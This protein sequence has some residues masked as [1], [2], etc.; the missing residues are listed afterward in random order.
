[1]NPFDKYMNDNFSTAAETYQTVFSTYDKNSDGFLD[2]TEFTELVKNLFNAKGDDTRI[3]SQLDTLFSIIDLNQDGLVNLEEFRYAWFYWIRQILRPVRALIVVDVQ[4]DF[5]S[6]SLSLSKC[7]A[8][9]DGSAVVPVVNSLLNQDLFDIV[10]YSSDWHPEDHISF[11]E[12]VKMRTMHPTSKTDAES[13]KVLDTVVFEFKGVP[14]VQTLWPKHCT[15]G[16]WGAQLHPDLKVAEK[17]FY[18]NKG[19]NPDVDSYSSFWDNDKLSKTEL[20][21]ILSENR[22]T[23]VYVSGLAYDVCVGFTAHHAVEHGFRTIFIEDAARGVSLDG[24]AKMREDLL[25]RGVYMT[26][27]SEVPALTKSEVRPLCL[28]I[29]AALNYQVAWKI[30]KQKTQSS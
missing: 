29:Q 10:V 15:Q 11:V 19:M 24:I 17:A 21:T 2:E 6:G 20:S 5:I 9:Q 27:S 13:A 14:R 26:D 12:N 16:S 30:V 8:G 22:V 25:A 18:I 28:G 7:A 1:M 4:N 23:D 3:P